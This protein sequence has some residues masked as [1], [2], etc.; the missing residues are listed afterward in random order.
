M[1]I[2]VAWICLLAPAMAA[3][4][5]GTGAWDLGPPRMDPERV[6][7]LAVYLAADNDLESEA[8]ADLNEMEAGLPEKGVEVIA[9]LDRAKAGD[10]SDG[11]W[12]D[13]RVFRV[14]RG[15][16]DWAIESEVLA[17]PGEVDLGDPKTLEGFLASAL[18]TFPAK[19]HA[20]AMGGYGRGW[21]GHAA[22]IDAPGAGEAIGEMTLGELRAA[23]E[24]AIGA[25]R[26]PKLDLIVLDM[27]LMAQIEVAAEIQ[28]LADA[29]VASEALLPPGGIPYEAILSPLAKD[30]SGSEAAAAIVAACDRSFDETGE[31]FATISAIDLG[32]LPDLIASLD[33]FV[34]KIEDAAPALWPLLSRAIFYAESYGERDDLDP[35]HDKTSSVDLIDLVKRMALDADRFP[36]GKDASGVED[37]AKRCVLALHRG[38]IRAAS[39]GV[40]IHAPLRKKMLLSAYEETAFARRTRWLPF[41]RK[42]HELQA[43]RDSPPAIRDL[44]IIDK[45]KGSPD[46][47]AA[48]G[49]GRVGFTVEGAGIL[50]A[51]VRD[52]A[53]IPGG[54]GFSVIS[55]VTLRD[56]TFESRERRAD[57]AIGRY[58]MPEFPDGKSEVERQVSWFALG[59]TDGRRTVD[60]TFDASD[61]VDVTVARV[62]AVY[63]DPEV[64]AVVADIT[65][66]GLA[67]AT[68]VVANISLAE[69]LM[70]R[71]RIA[72]RPD[73][74]V[75]PIRE[76]I[77]GD[78][79][80]KLKRTGTLKW[81]DGLEVAP[82]LTG[83]GILASL[84][85]VE[86][87]G[88]ETAREVF[89]YK[90]EEH[91]GLG[92]LEYESSAFEAKDLVGIWTVEKGS[93][94]LEG[95][96]REFEATGETLSFTA[97]ARGPNRL[98]YAWKRPEA[99]RPE[100][101]SA[102]IAG[103]AV[104]SLLFFRLVR[105]VEPVR[106]GLYFGYKVSERER[107]TFI[108]KD[109][110]PCG[111]I[112][113]VPGAPRAE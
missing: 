62:P 18:R 17:S 75:S 43:R 80:W 50:R 99:D 53:R 47:V 34:R 72:P 10:A 42:L 59:V 81:G 86:T 20:L 68:A 19:R 111:A 44:R 52:L 23:I 26:I 73:A 98:L 95:E 55:T 67:R 7:T 69:G 65:F 56:P 54:G 82:R 85:E 97:D 39:N 61:L 79:G 37:A 15:T 113:L 30:V 87:I 70:V 13:A 16:D 88:G 71:R 40:A 91:T 101:G 104:P 64:G 48:E 93:I 11:D 32:K 8:L 66:T 24:G 27:S 100:R 76:V 29:L 4:P 105:D 108:L 102:R 31:R 1:R 60:A 94:G 2:R 51:S 12:T 46:T 25:A 110:T 41:L 106:S 14:L 78:A 28:P 3:E 83:H 74:D 9:L 84:I 35:N 58:L 103:D 38:W 109:T 22:D 49:G 45:A 107:T 96:D 36:A 33:A 57:G 63:A 90:I 77:E 92:A 112:R 21:Q 5:Q 6:W 89:T